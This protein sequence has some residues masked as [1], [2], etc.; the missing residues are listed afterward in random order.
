MA[1]ILFLNE[2][3]ALYMDITEG[4]EIPENIAYFELAEGQSTFCPRY[5]LVGGDLVDNYPDF[6]D[7]QVAE[8]I[9]EE[10]RQKALELEALLKGQ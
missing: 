3:T 5:S 9:Q 10:Q 4:M 6:T 8:T 7:E 1:A 2:K